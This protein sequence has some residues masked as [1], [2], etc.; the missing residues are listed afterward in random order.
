LTRRAALRAFTTALTCLAATPALA[1]QDAVPAAQ[2]RRVTAPPVIDGR[3]DDAVWSQAIPTSDFRQR[4]PKEGEPAT[5]RTVVRILYDQSMLY[6]GAELLDR[7]PGAI[8]ASELRRDNELS[9]DDT[10][11]VLLDTFHD[12]RNA[13]LFRVNARGTRFD[14]VVRNESHEPTTE[15]DEQWTAEARVSESGWTVELA[16]PF[17]VLRFRSEQEQSWGLNFERLIK[18]KNEDTYWAGWDRNYNFT[19]VS[20]AGHLTG[21]AGIKQGGRLR[22]RP[23]VVAGVETLQAVPDPAGSDFDPNIGLDDVKILVTSDLTADLAVNPDFAQTEVDEQRVNLT[24]FSLFFPEKRQFFIEGADSFKMSAPQV[25]W[26]SPPAELF[27]SR[28]IGLSEDGNPIPIVAGGKL[29]GNLGGFELGVMDVQTDESAG[30][31]GENFAVARVRREVLGRSYFGGIFTNRLDGGEYNRVWGADARFVLLD[32]LTLTGMLA[33]NTA[34]GT[35]GTEW[36]RQLGAGWD[37]DFL[38]TGVQY[39]DIDPGFDPGIGFV[40][41]NDRMVAAQFA[42]MPRPKS[43]IVRQ[44]EF[45]PEATFHHDHDGLLLTRELVFGVEAAFQTG[46]E[47]DVGAGNTVEQLTEPFRIAPGVV[48][49]PGRY[50]WNSVELRGRSF[51]GRQ[52]SIEGSATFGGFFSGTK[53]SFEVSGNYRPDAHFSFS[54]SYEFNHVDLEEG[55][56]N[57]NLFGLRAN[58]SFTTNLLTAAYIQYN[59]SGE[60]AA[61]QLRLNY[62]YRSIDNVYL[63]YNDTRFTGGRYESRSNRSLVFKVT[64]SIH[65]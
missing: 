5:E 40:E 34:T 39:L 8:R 1:A 51:E 62:I 55:A 56:F 23:Y 3:L 49:P 65:R 61:V 21:L 30:V 35:D 58:V 32:Y 20:Q 14:A 2:A 15:W 50:E 22:I 48:L 29:S 26:G 19:H 31:A 46:D 9:S 47:L 42:V 12:H 59:S 45:S 41:R 36:L 25:G 38:R 10:F 6:I 63:V 17:K 54:P 52:A 16:I 28:R 53:Q 7:E 43:G 4:D 13:F 37:D 24:R 64:Y 60:L 18:R 57:T 44:F 27:Y 11:A 33:G